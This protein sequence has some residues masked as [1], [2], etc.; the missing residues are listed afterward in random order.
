MVFQHDKSKILLIIHREGR[1]YLK[2]AKGRVSLCISNAVFPCSC[3]LNVLNEPDTITI[4]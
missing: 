4:Q 2:K 3:V 1:T